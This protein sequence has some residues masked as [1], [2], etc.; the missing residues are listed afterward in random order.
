LCPQGILRNCC[1]MSRGAENT[2]FFL[3]H[4]LLAHS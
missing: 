4:L 2:P 3:C 1:W